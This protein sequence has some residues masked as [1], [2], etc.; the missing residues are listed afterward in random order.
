[1]YEKGIVWLPRYQWG[2]AAGWQLSAWEGSLG[3]RKERTAP[4]GDGAGA[5]GHAGS[6]PAWPRGVDAP[7]QATV[8]ATPSGSFLC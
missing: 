7:E 3:M 4:V 8:P 1:M 6:Q 5:V 2:A